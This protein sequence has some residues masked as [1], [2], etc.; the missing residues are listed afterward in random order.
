M[1]INMGNKGPGLPDVGI[2]CSFT[3]QI[4]LIVD[5]RSDDFYYAV[6]N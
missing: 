6:K 1:F 3:R 5:L 4:I 2:S